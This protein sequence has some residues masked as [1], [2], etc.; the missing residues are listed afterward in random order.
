M[1][2]GGVSYYDAWPYGRIKFLSIGKKGCARVSY[3]SNMN[4]YFDCHTTS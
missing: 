2:V 4:G 1:M 3:V